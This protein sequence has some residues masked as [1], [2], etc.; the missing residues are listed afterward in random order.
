MKI[1]AT[2]GALDGTFSSGT[3]FNAM[4]KSVI[5]N[6]SDLYI[7]G[8]FT[9]YNGTSRFGVVK[10]NA[11]TGTLDNTFDPGTGYASKLVTNLRL[12]SG[13]LYVGS[14]A[15]T[16]QDLFRFFIN[17]ISPTDASDLDAP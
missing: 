10:M 16:Y 7:G 9:S 14:Y 8:G 13:I 17:R 5:I 3:G 4:P 15:E 2:S 6:G 11:T 1:S 12:D